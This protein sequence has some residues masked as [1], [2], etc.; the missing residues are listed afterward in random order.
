[1]IGVDKE[2][3]K[4]EFSWRKAESAHFLA[5][6]DESWSE[7]GLSVQDYELAGKTAGLKSRYE[8]SKDRMI[9]GK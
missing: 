8:V 2:A 9:F 1:M 3:Q 5:S 7:D 4:I 6:S